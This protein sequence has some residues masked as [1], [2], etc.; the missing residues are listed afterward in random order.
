M[1]ASPE[2][3]ARD[4][5]AV[6]QRAGGEASGLFVLRCLGGLVDSGRPNRSGVTV[7]MTELLGPSVAPRPRVHMMAEPTALRI[8]RAGRP[9]ARDGRP[10]PRWVTGAP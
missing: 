7:A 4:C 1:T 10:R 5:M 3:I 6:D 9:A 2:G 8:T